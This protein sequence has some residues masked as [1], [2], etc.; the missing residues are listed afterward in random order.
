MEKEVGARGTPFRMGTV[1]GIFPYSHGPNG[2]A[3]TEYFTKMLWIIFKVLS[4]GMAFHP[5]IS[6]GWLSIIIM[7]TDPCSE[8]KDPNSTNGKKKGKGI[9]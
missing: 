3:F 4:D 5:R 1:T 6:K 7:P 9:E 8:V 2:Y